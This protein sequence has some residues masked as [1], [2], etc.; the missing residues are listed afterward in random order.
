MP[1]DDFAASTFEHSCRC[2]R[3]RRGGVGVVGLALERGVEAC[4]SSSARYSIHADVT[5]HSLTIL[6]VLVC[7]H[8]DTGGEAGTHLA[9]RA[10][11]NEMS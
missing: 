8:R 7:Q 2:K 6:A 10:L 1:V 3:V 5:T 11:P 4:M 9:E